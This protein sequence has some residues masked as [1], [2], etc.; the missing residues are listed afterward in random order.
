MTTENFPNLRLSQ[1]YVGK[2]DAKD[3]LL[4]A[5][6][7]EKVLFENTFFTPPHIFVEDFLKGSRFYIVGLKGTGK[8][9]FLRF[10][11][12]AARRLPDAAT[13]FILFKS[14]FSE[15]ERKEV[16]GSDESFEI[17]DDSLAPG[18]KLQDDYELVWRWFFHR[19]IVSM[20]FEAAV[21]PIEQNEDLE[22]YI[23]CVISAYNPVEKSGLR[24]LFP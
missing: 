10:M 21:S 1:L 7:G 8:T 16:A 3:E 14:Q 9:A 17:A 15:E 22:R 18:T 2:T 5:D 13:S 19:K 20:L 11:D 23:D 24:R 12:I 6:D 4:F